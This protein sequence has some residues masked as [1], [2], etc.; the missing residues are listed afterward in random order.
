MNGKAL[1]VCHV[2]PGTLRASRAGAQ[3]AGRGG[4]G[5]SVGDR[6]RGGGAGVFD[7]GMRAGCHFKGVNIVKCF[8]TD[9]KQ[10]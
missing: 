2:P 9:L 5:L 4:A 1:A 6:A 8:F 7:G 10:A 3:G